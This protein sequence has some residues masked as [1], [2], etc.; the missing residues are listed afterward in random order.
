MV[1]KSNGARIKVVWKLALAVTYLG[2]VKRGLANVRD[3][4]SLLGVY[5]KWGHALQ[6]SW[7]RSPLTA[8]VLF[9]YTRILHISSNGFEFK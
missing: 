8:R 7:R 1:L 9:H 6:Y 4:V 3:D 2:C 5:G